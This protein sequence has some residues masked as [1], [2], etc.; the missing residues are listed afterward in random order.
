MSSPVFQDTTA[1]PELH[2]EEDQRI[3]TWIELPAPKNNKLE[4][5]AVVEAVEGEEEEDQHQIKMINQI[6]RD[7]RDK[8]GNH[9]VF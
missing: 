4:V 9:D 7:Q 2:E 1:H 3:S 8:H 5:E 6:Q